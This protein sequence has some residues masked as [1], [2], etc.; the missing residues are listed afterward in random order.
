MKKLISIEKA[1]S[2]WAKEMLKKY[3]PIVQF[4]DEKMC[5]N[6]GKPVLEMRFVNVECNDPMKM[7]TPDFKWSY[8][9]PKDEIVFTEV[10]L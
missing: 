3:G 5:D 7:D 4:A 6:F 1:K 8:W 2:K 9:V 10:K